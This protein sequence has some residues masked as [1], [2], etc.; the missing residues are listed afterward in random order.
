MQDLLR[1]FRWIDFLVGFQHPP[2]GPD[3]VT[4]PLRMFGVAVAASSV[5]NT[6]V[7]RNVAEQRKWEIELFS[8]SSILLDGIEAD[9]QDLDVL[10]IEFFFMVAEPAP[11]IGS[12]RCV[13]LGIE[14]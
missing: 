2:I 7:A 12:A 5:R 1:V 10:V 4:D 13:G 11:F 14:P 9:A 3:E 8:E 6:G